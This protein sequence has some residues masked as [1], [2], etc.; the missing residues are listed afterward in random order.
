M[1]LLLLFRL[2]KQRYDTWEVGIKQAHLG[3]A[4]LTEPAPVSNMLSS[5]P[6]HLPHWP[7]TGGAGSTGRADAAIR[8]KGAM[9]HSTAA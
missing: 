7:P 8:C 6:P 3:A 5:V 1:E 9:L 2:F 4:P